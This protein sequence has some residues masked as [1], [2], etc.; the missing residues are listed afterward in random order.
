[1]YLMQINKYLI[2]SVEYTNKTFGEYVD[3]FELYVS[4]N[5]MIYY[6]NSRQF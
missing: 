3:H 2:W 6:D 5:K 1:M 4:Q